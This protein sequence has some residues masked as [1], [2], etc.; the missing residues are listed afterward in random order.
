L[1]CGGAYIKLLSDPFNTEDFD[2]STPYTIMFGPDKCGGTNKVHF[3][4]R[5]QNP[6]TKKFEEKHFTSAPVIGDGKVSHLYTVHI[7]ENNSVS[8]FVDLEKQASG[9][10]FT[11]FAPSVNPPKTID[12][13]EDKKPLDWVDE[14]KIDDPEAK[15]PGDWDEDAPKYIP[16]PDALKP[17]EWDENEP[18]QVP[19]PEAVKPADWD[20]EEDGVWT[21]PMVDNPRCATVGCG[22]WKPE[23]IPNPEYKG[24]WKAPKIPNPA[25]K[26]KWKP[27]QIPNPDHFEDLHPNHFAPIG[28]IGIEIWTMQDKITFDNIYVGNDIEDAFRFAEETWKV[29]HDVEEKLEGEAK[30]KS[31]EVPFYVPVLNYV[32]ENILIVSLVTLSV[33]IIALLI[34]SFAFSSDSEPKKEKKEKKETKK[35]KEEEEKEE[36]KE[37]EE[38]EKEEEKDKK[39]LR[40]RNVQKDK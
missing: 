34:C 12:D 35:E 38:E 30:K 18:S 27:N 10:L 36:E 5:H 22:K 28:G 15:K 8:V 24:K 14:D 19:D 6:L 20:D 40:K 26:G 13:P 2:G 32:K 33:M 3:I 1:E 31:E 4:F 29:K 9:D 21:A 39:G 16:D 25:F 37:E 11:N 7:A 23:K 17:E